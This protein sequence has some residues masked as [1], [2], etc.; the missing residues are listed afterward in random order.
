MGRKA[1][2]VALS[3]GGSGLISWRACIH[4]R[5]SFNKE[6]LLA[7]YLVEIKNA[8]RT[9][10]TMKPTLTLLLLASLAGAEPPMPTFVYRVLQKS[11][12]NEPANTP[13]KV[14][15]DLKQ[16]VPDDIKPWTVVSLELSVAGYNYLNGD[17][18]LEFCRRFDRQ[19]Y[20]FRIE[21][22]DPGIPDP[23][24]K[25]RWFRPE[26][27]REIL[28]ACPN[29]E[30]A[31]TGETFWAFT[32][33]ENP[34]KDQWL[35][36][37][38][39]V[40]ASQKRRFILGEG[41]WNVG[42]WTRFLAKHHDEL[43]AESLGP[44]LVAMHK[45]TKPWA[46]MQNLSALQGAWVTGLIGNYGI[47]NDQ[48]CWTYSS[49]GHANEFPPYNKKD[50]NHKKLPYTFFL[51][52]WLWGISQGAQYSF[53]ENPL[54]FT[55]EGTAN[56]TFAKYLH[57]F[58]K[59]VGE[60]HI[61]PAREAVMKK[62]KAV[63][64]PFGTYPTSKGLWTYDPLKVFF[65]YLDE[66]TA[67]APKSHDPFTVLFRN[68]YGFAQE[69]G[70]TTAAGGMFP[71]EPSLPDRLT[72]ETL[73]NTAR[74]YATPILSHPAEEPPAGMRRLKLAKLRTDA[75]MKAAFDALYPANPSVAYAVEVDDSF[76]VLN[77]NENRDADQ[78]FKLPLGKGALRFME[79]DLP[80]QNLIFGK[81]EGA[82]R[83]WF[84]TNGYHGD[85]KTAGQRYQCIPK[86][87][88]I[89]F[90]CNRNPKITVE[91]GTAARM[92]VTKPWDQNTWKVTLSFDHT[93]GPSNFTISTVP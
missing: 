80:F 58:I 89:T 24:D 47:W 37:V 75:T 21:I 27:I 14:A 66:P 55:R 26:E 5:R 18:P 28:T 76:F 46:T 59:G 72:R 29:C 70:G 17:T 9:F 31:E 20:R 93:D 23:P 22:A 10:A 8:Q 3:G 51:R 56:S 53:T 69:Y 45:N 39:R 11:F 60:H 34:A 12:R 82:D 77:G 54:T 43:R 13:E 88:V 81:R 30:G 49:F 64:D 7:T 78:F 16:L 91:D 71:R 61:T 87:T 63:V 92:T 36:D 38:L 2:S 79:G 48:W 15:A 33:G 52:Q 65:T 62:I 6:L 41:T 19:G 85:G 32:G 67:F 25:R 42:H 68:T 84:Q 40:C 74:Y 50:E 35:M 83:F 90:T 1:A 44:W 4:H 86:P 73:P 57:P